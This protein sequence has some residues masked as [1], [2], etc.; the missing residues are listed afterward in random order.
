MSAAPVTLA[1]LSKISKDRYFDMNAGDV[2]NIFERTYKINDASHRKTYDIAEIYQEPY[3][4]KYNKLKYAQICQTDLWVY[5][6]LVVLGMV[7]TT[8][9]IYLGLLSMN[10]DRQRVCERKED[11]T[12]LPGENSVYIYFVDKFFVCN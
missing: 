3:K 12:L 6:G 8:L 7:L 10:V 11:K 2:D 1:T 4:E 5:L 9:I